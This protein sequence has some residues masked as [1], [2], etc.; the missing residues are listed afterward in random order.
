[1]LASMPV[2]F[3][4]MIDAAACSQ[5]QHVIFANMIDATACSQLHQSRIHL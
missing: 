3:A 1:M 4:N 5:L 2:T